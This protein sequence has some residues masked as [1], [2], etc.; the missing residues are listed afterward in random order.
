M[1]TTFSILLCKF[2]TLICHLFRK[3]GTVFPGS[4]VRK[5]QPHVLDNIKYPEFVIVVTGSSG[6]GST[7]SMLAH[8]LEV[9]GKNV[10]WDPSGSNITRATTTLILNK[11]NTFSHKL[12]GDVL[13]LEM[14][15][16]CITG[17]FKKGIITH[18][19]ITN[20]TRD[21]P[22]R[23]YHPMAVLDD[24][25]KDIDDDVHLI[26]NADDPLL[27]RLRYLGKEKIT[28]FGIAKTKYDIKKPSYAVDFAY[29]PSCQMKLK[30]DS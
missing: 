22:G 20:I 14:D 5:I 8:L 27:D 9:A 23:N 13:L 15:E 30:Y 16:K 7:V 2:A 12:K 1:R 11:T 3:N 19:C 17:A 24:I 26:L 4:L 10:I 21:Q 25:L 18:L 6:K 28:T 29:C